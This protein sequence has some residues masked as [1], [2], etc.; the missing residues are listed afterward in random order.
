MLQLTKRAKYDAHASC[1][2]MDTEEAQTAYVQLLRSLEP[3]FEP[4]AEDATPGTTHNSCA[5]LSP[6]SHRTRHS[7]LCRWLATQLCSER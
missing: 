7:R 5:A 3:R 2:G 6:T 1:A 4:R